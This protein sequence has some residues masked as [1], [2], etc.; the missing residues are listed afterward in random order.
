[1]HQFLPIFRWKGFNIFL[2]N[3]ILIR[4]NQISTDIEVKRHHNIHQNDIQM[5]DTQQ[6]D[7]QKLIAELQPA[8]LH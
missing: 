7:A 2:T 3:I 4:I 1:M 6:K 8:E 5:N